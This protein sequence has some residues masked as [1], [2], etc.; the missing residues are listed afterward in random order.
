M[1]PTETLEPVVWQG[2]YDG[3]WKGFITDASHAHPAKFS[4]RLI[5]RIY[6]HLLDR[7]WIQRGD[8]VGD[9]FGGVGTGALVAAYRG[10]HHISVELEPRFVA[11][12][13]ENI[14]S[15]RGKLQQLGYPA[16]IIIQG[17]SRRFHE[18]IQPTISAIVTSPPYADS[19]NCSKSGIDWTKA[20]RPER[21]IHGPNRH[22]VQASAD[23]VMKYG[24]AE[25][26]VGA[27][28][29]GDLNAIVA[30]PPFTQGYNGG[31]GINKNGYGINGEDKVG[32]RTYQ[33]LA[34]ERQPE[35]VEVLNQETYWLACQTIYCSCLLALR[36]KG[37]IALVVKDYCRDGKRV[38]LCDDTARLL[39]HCGFTMTERIQ[40]MLVTER[41][42]EDLFEGMKTKR[43]ERK[44]F[45]RRL[46]ESKLPAG[47][48]RRIDYEEVL[49]AQAP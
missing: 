18:L 31:G 33:A 26:Q 23:H 48:E 21:W 45:F 37:I 47:D 46:Y 13:K 8:I 38:R 29:S 4:R 17:D 36:P 10:L 20:K 5:E 49:I 2:C 27:L 42:E 24:E 11:L 39:E 22:A 34:G 30:S 28:H 40:A 44:S 6:D 15:H 25:G 16:P 32:A 1:M 3:G 43:K 35:N 12:A 7:G 9:C 19:V 41:E 14:E